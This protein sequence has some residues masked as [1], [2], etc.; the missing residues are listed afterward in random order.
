MAAPQRILIVLATMMLASTPAHADDP[1]LF[2]PDYGLSAPIVATGS[3]LVVSYY[4][5]EATTVFGHTLWAFTAAQYQAN[6][7]N[8]CFW[9]MPGGLCG[10]IAGTSVGVKPYGTT[11]PPS[12]DTPVV[13]P[14]IAWATGTEVIFA[15]GVNQGDM[16]NWFFSGD[17]LR[18]GASYNLA[19]LAYFGTDGVP[20]NEGVG[21]IPGT[22]GKY[23][24]GFEDVHYE[25]SDWDFDNAIFAVD[26]DGIT[27][28]SEVVP[29]P[30]SMTLLATGLVGL[31]AARR[32]RR[33]A[34]PTA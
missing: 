24:F 15:L 19:H 29:E 1:K 11:T 27:P 4:G 6:L 22:V 25:H 32:R 10:G 12:L 9:S 34:P 33:S 20:G 14:G 21:I 23:L 7:A 28:P 17:P 5:W 31:A 18:N 3:N 16:F 30:A 13:S 2:G 26:F 8:Q